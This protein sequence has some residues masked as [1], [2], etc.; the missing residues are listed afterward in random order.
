MIQKL[1]ECGIV[2]VCII[3]NILLFSQHT[4][5]D[6]KSV[7]ISGK[8]D[9]LPYGYVPP[10]IGN[11]NL[12]MIVD[13]TGSQKQATYYRMV[14][15]IYKAGRRYGPPRDGLYPFGNFDQK[16]MVGGNVIN[17]PEKWTQQLDRNNSLM[18]SRS[19]YEGGIVVTSQVFCHLTKDI[20]VVKKIF[21]TQSEK[22]QEVNYSF[23]YNFPTSA[24]RLNGEVNLN[25]KIGG[26]EFVYKADAY[27]PFEGITS[28]FSD[29]KTEVVIEDP[30]AVFK[31]SFSLKKGS[32][33]EIIY[34]M[35]FNDS[36][37]DKDFLS[38]QKGLISEVLQDGFNGLN[39]S[40]KKEWNDFFAKSWV[41]LPEPKLEEVYNTSMYHLRANATKWSFPIGIFPTHW[42]GRY[43]GWDETFAFFGLV[44]SN[45]LDISQRVPDFRLKT[46]PHAMDRA[47]HTSMTEL[48]KRF[49]GAKY[50]WETLE[51]GWEGT[52]FPGF[53]VEHVFHMAHIAMAAW[54]QY[55]YSGDKEYL[56][57]IAYPLI[58][59][60]NR[61]FNAYNVYENQDGSLYIGKVTDLERLGPARQNAFLTTAGVIYTMEI[62]AKA[63]DVLGQ[64]DS[65]TEHWK[66]VAAKLRE[67]L[68]NN[69]ERYIP[70]PGC[71]EESIGTLGGLYPYPIFDKTNELQRNA[72]YWFQDK[73]LA[74]GNVTS[75]GD[76]I[77]SWYAAKLAA[78]FAKLGDRTQTVHWLRKTTS[79]SGCF[80]ELFEIHEPKISTI[81]W[82][83]AV[84]GAYVYAVNQML[85]QNTENEIHIAPAVP[86]T[87]TN[88]SFKLGCYDNYT[89]TVKVENGKLVQIDLETEDQN[90][91]IDKVLVIPERLFNT[92]NLKKSL[93]KSIELKAGNYYVPIQL[94]SGINRVIEIKK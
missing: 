36:M 15:G 2:F 68:P 81:P 16:I 74:F 31:S 47:K 37:D 78:T 50:P 11:G 10:L 88:F 45:H 51:D 61:Y 29:K 24:K 91:R 33:F 6:Q 42:A 44:S 62:A 85:V 40:H 75:K 7:I 5:A 19:E 60:C 69:G 13:Y 58:R 9:S 84:G 79:S 22:V 41:K 25:D 86:E 56:K 67:T 46:M 20:V 35:V 12:N 26:V 8:K 27:I 70:Y 14:P 76:S 23:T 34:Y 55:E 93:L 83:A 66:I 94:T 49:Y 38:K 77:G 64:S 59:E 92:R 54:M 21:E 80:G 57:N 48:N 28:V 39:V 4:Q 82:Y 65:E 52:S 87:W 32:S 71:K 43:F 18:I 1:K 53:W 17:T 3:L 90:K 73:G 72:V 63:A 89:A 30:K